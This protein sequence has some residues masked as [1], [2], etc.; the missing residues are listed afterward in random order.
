MQELSACCTPQDVAARPD[1]STP[2]GECTR[3]SGDEARAPTEQAR[4]GAPKRAPRNQLKA[5]W[6]GGDREYVEAFEKNADAR[7]SIDEDF[8]KNKPSRGQLCLAALKLSGWALQ[9]NQ[10]LRH[11][12]A[13]DRIVGANQQLTDTAVPDLRQQYDAEVAARTADKAASDAALAELQRELDTLKLKWLGFAAS[14]REERE[15]RRTEAQQAELSQECRRASAAEQRAAAVERELADARSE[16]DALRVAPSRAQARCEAEQARRC[17]EAAAAERIAELAADLLTAHEAQQQLESTVR[18]EQIRRGLVE[19]QV[20][21]ARQVVENAKQLDS[22]LH[23]LERREQERIKELGAARE[24]VAEQRAELERLRAQQP[25]GRGVERR[26]FYEALRT[27]IPIRTSADRDDAPFNAR[28]IEFQRR[29]VDEANVSFEGAATANAL[30]LS[31]HHG[32]PSPDRLVCAKSFQ[33]AFYRGG[34]LDNEREAA[35]NRACPALWS[36]ASD[37][38]K[39]TQM[40]VYFKFNHVTCQPEAHPLAAADLFRNECHENVAAIDMKA[41]ERMGLNPARLINVLM[42]GTEHAVQE[43]VDV[44]AGN[45]AKAQALPNGSRLD[46]HDKAL[47]EWCCIH[48]WALEEKCGMEAAFPKEYLV[49]A[50]RLLWE[51]VASPES[52]RRTYYADVWVRECKLPADCFDLLA[53]MPEPTSSKWEVMYKV[54]KCLLPLLEPH[55]QLLVPAARRCML[56][57][58]L[59]RCR[60][61]NCGSM[62]DARAQ[63]VVHPHTEKVKL[64]SGALADL[65]MIAAIYLTV[66]ACGSSAT[67]TLCGSARARRATAALRSP[68]CAT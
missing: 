27:F 42:D 7:A 26:P 67:P 62:D 48:G 35:A 64:I 25:A 68:S 16:L 12:K 43:G 9:S 28:A 29:L 3:S 41:L 31:M 38:Q 1:T 50:T 49:D 60:E 61:L 19:A 63:R 37:S 54:C 34:L 23:N 13:G 4:V 55:G 8:R 39:G 46:Y 32:E 65:D 20:E 53:K 40:M 5:T 57:I 36:F 15:L 52:G 58:F 33:N 66:D 14:Q 24:T 11:D 21:T 56:E 59:D 44:V 51:L 6:E 47:R 18:S 2:D 45:L 22:K 30:V 10:T 17:S